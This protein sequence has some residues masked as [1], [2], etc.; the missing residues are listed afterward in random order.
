MVT[1]LVATLGVVGLV[2]TGGTA[3]GEV[4]PAQE[5]ASSKLKETGKKI[6]S[7]LECDSKAVKKGEAVDPLC[8]QKAI[9]KFAEKWA[10][11]EAK[12]GCA[13]TGDL[14]TI[15]GKADALRDTLDTSIG[16][17]DPGP[18]SKCSAAEL[19]ASFALK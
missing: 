13:T 12:G 15:E 9:D 17:G 14:A 7:L 18:V 19:A 1:R 6:N 5:C 11:A 2:A 3:L 10:K 8:L 4:T 16:L